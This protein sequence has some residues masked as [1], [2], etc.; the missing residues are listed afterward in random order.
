MPSDNGDEPPVNKPLNEIQIE[1]AKIKIDSLH[2]IQN[3]P[4]GFAFPTICCC[5]RLCQS[6]PTLKEV[7]EGNEDHNQPLLQGHIE[8]NAVGKGPKV[9]KEEKDR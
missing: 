6:R 8:M 1:M 7:D 3:T 4:I 5:F 2:V 9:L